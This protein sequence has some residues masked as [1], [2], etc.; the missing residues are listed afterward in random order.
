MDQ[1]LNTHGSASVYQNARFFDTPIF[2]KNIL[3]QICFSSFIH[4]ERGEP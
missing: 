3:A 4:V 1:S 2:I